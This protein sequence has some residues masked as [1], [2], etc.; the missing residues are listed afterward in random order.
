MPH[1]SP[2]QKQ[3]ATVWAEK[4][5]KL[6]ARAEELCAHLR[7]CPEEYLIAHAQYAANAPPIGF[8]PHRDQLFD[9]TCSAERTL[10]TPPTTV[11]E[12]V[13][14]VNQSMFLSQRYMAMSSEQDRD[15][16]IEM[17]RQRTALTY[18]LFLRSIP[19]FDHRQAYFAKNPPE[20]EKVIVSIP[21]ALPQPLPHSPA[22]LLQ[23]FQTRILDL[24]FASRTS[25]TQSALKSTQL[26]F[27]NIR[28]I[29]NLCLASTSSQIQT[30]WKSTDWPPLPVRKP[31]TQNYFSLFLRL[32]APRQSVTRL[33]SFRYS[34][35]SHPC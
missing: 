32:R 13:T 6:E 5:V 4:T 18:A 19:F 11:F 7:T 33:N 16:H 21:A 10:E 9:V 3:A 25:K 27:W 22:N 8:V 35:P 20:D 26:P 34:P 1:L 28:E 15:A 14:A 23:S 2:A 30:G 12:Y 24:P 29:P 31:R 17:L